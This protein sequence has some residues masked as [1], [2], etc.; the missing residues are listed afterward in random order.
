MKH[1]F[2]GFL[3]DRLVVLIIDL[4]SSFRNDSRRIVSGNRTIEFWEIDRVDVVIVS[5]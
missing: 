2:L 4:F 5:L 3:V 1:S